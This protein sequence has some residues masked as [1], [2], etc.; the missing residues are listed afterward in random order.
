MPTALTQKLHGLFH[1]ILRRVKS[2]GGVTVIL[3]GLCLW[4][5]E[6]YAGNLVTDFLSA[7]A[8]RIPELARLPI[9][10]A[11]LILV[12]WI[13]LWLAILFIIAIVETWPP[14]R[15]TE[16]R[17]TRQFMVEEFETILKENKELERKASYYHALHSYGA[18][19]PAYNPLSEGEHRFMVSRVRELGPALEAVLSGATKV[20]SSLLRQKP[21]DESPFYWIHER[22]DSVEH[23]NVV[24]LIK[25]LKETLA[26]GD[27]RP[28]LAQLYVGYREWRAWIVRFAKMT[29]QRL[30][31]SPAYA[32]WMTSETKYF[33]ELLKALENPELAQVRRTVE[34]Y[35][36]N[37]GEPEQLPRARSS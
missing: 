13:A 30:E 5:A 18:E 35:I 17:E 36:E 11:G 29:G 26:A 8:K 9:G 1:V 6:E 3:L 2:R 23:G 28:F 34:D 4:A 20:W 37:K 10:V 32:D 14:R 12:G 21:S 19:L 31:S 15:A 24:R 25:G 27:P 16:D 22:I 7:L 33:A